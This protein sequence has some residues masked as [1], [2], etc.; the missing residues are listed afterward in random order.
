[1]IAEESWTNNNHIV[2]QVAGHLESWESQPPLSYRG[3]LHY[4]CS[5]SK[6]TSIN[7]DKTQKFLEKCSSSS[8]NRKSRLILNVL[9]LRWLSEH[10]TSF[11]IVFQWPRL[12]VQINAI[13]LS[14][15]PVHAELKRVSSLPVTLTVKEKDDFLVIC[16][17]ICKYS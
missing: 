9:K 14:C 15:I 4:R 1:M 3:L 11:Y 13:S 5:K 8:N 17:I 7:R 16:R 2:M 6:L 12:H 10:I